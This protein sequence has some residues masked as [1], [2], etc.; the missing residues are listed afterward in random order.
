M[1]QEDQLIQKYLSHVWQ[2]FTQMKLAPQPEIIARAEGAV[3][4]TQK[5]QAI[6]DGIGSWWVNV[7]G[8]N[9]AELNA[10]LHTQLKNFE[11]TIFAGLSHAPGIEL[12]TELS[13]STHDNLPRVF[14]SDNGS[15]AVEIALKMAYQFNYNKGETNRREFVCLK[16]AY[17]GD[18]IGAM[19]VGDRGVFHRAYEP[20]LFDSHV[21]VPP[22]VAFD[23][24]LLLKED[25]PEIQVALDQARQLFA[26]H[27]EHICA[28]LVEP[29]VQGASAGFAMHPPAYLRALY[30]ICKKHGSFF[31]ADEVYTGCGR[32]GQMYACELADFWPDIMALSKG[33][34]GGYLPFAATLCS[35]EIY[36]GFYSDD[37]MHALFHG[38]SMTGSA[39]GCAV[40]LA[41]MRLLRKGGAILQAAALQA[42]H[43]RYQKKITQGKLGK[44]IKEC[45][46]LGSLGV[47]E[48]H[49]TGGYT[50]DFGWRIM[51]ESIKRGA[52]IRPLGS[53]IYLTPPYNIRDDQLEQL[54]GVLEE[55]LQ[56]ELENRP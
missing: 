37:R 26:R 19:S 7:H 49:D 9:R 14:Y 53:S 22:V 1:V 17:H 40:S 51:G 18:T 56:I 54:Y 2:P 48:L 30:K 42:K 21:L 36:Q 12:A 44:Y 25:A 55:V 34:S 33:L 38:H 10:A 15:T 4:F 35:E 6:I 5:G 50:S 41:S 28:V 39:L 16:G 52:L 45:R 47:I 24:L 46:S 11:H 32:L 8:H 20:L 23:K 27:G 3:L 31:I 29:I 13:D 43:S